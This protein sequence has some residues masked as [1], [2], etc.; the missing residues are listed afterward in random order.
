MALLE[1]RNI[2]RRFADF[3][4]VSEVSF[5]VESGEFF[6]LLGPSGC[7]KTTILRMIAGFDLPDAGQILLD[8][9][10]LARTPAEK[11][12]IH[13]VFQSYALF[14]HL[15]VGQNVAFPLRMA[16]VAETEL[17][18][19]VRE[20][21]EQ[22]HLAEL[23]EHYPHEISGG[24]KQRVALARGLVNRPRLLLLDEPLGALDL[25]LREEMQLELIKLQREV[26]VTF[27]FVT[28]AQPEALALSHRIAVMNR[29]RI[30][31][32]DEP[33]R[34]YSFPS[35]RFVADFIGNC[36]L[37]EAAVIER[38]DG[39]LRLAAAGLGEI[40]APAS[41]AEKAGDKGVLALR[42][43]QVRIGAAN[44]AS[45]DANRFPGTVRDFL[46]VGD[47]TTYQVALDNGCQLAALRPND[48]PG[49]ARF[50]E[51]GDRVTL[52]WAAD[53]GHYVR[54]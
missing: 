37:L 26:G 50:F 34:I 35:N 20:T 54:D 44:S 9:R 15:S 10:D 43:E 40:R 22:V 4:A 30:E 49:R 52:S 7:G 36:N 3:E 12:P 28:H 16:G 39:L 25:K 24:Q 23:A 2:T 53:A 18:R 38:R 48:A 8:G 33:S 42:P 5:T 29:G 19:R 14:P 31:Q 51:V 41:D 27:V 13:T 1:I 32:L 11:R 46:Y 45:D 21:L 17:R 6:T 47:V